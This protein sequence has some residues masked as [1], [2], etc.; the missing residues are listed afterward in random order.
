MNDIKKIFWETIKIL[1]NNEN[2]NLL[3]QSFIGSA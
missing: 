3:M 2:D 1:E